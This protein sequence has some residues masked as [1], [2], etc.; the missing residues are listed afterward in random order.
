MLLCWNMNGVKEKFNNEEVQ[1]LFSN[2]DILIIIETHFKVR[3]RCP[4]E[5]ELVGKSVLLCEKTGRDGVA[6]YARK[7]LKLSFRVYH[8]I[9]PDAVVVKLCNTNI[10]IVA[11]YVVPDNSKFKISNI[12]SILDFIIQNFPRDYV[13]MMGDL[14]ARCATPKITH[15]QKYFMNPDSVINANGRKLLSLCWDRN[16][17]L[18]EQV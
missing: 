8:D 18:A 6:V 17:T 5:F 12:F 9:S 15:T 10:V 3:H 11:P 16:L 7:I 13:Y 2:Y 1:L 4:D 14:N